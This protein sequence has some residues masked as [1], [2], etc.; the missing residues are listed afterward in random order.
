[1]PERRG[2]GESDP[3][4]VDGATAGKVGWQGDQDAG[5]I[6]VGTVVDEH[7]YWITLAEVVVV[8]H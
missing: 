4:Y 6:A 8:H 1:M 3:G 2:I 7:D 5:H